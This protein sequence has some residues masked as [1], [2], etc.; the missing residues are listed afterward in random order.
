MDSG[1]GRRC[2]GEVSCFDSQNVGL[3]VEMRADSAEE[4][5]I[6]SSGIF[7]HI[8]TIFQQDFSADFSMGFTDG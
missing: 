6:F 1:S 3:I 7:Q 8:S 5:L 4:I 2:S